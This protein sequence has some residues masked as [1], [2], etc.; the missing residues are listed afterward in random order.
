M[1]ADRLAFEPAAALELVSVAKGVAL[2]MVAYIISSQTGACLKNLASYRQKHVSAR[3]HPLQ[4]A[5]AHQTPTL[6]LCMKRCSSHLPLLAAAALTMNSWQ[7]PAV[8]VSARPIGRGCILVR[9]APTWLAHCFRV[10][11]KL[12]RA[13]KSCRDHANERVLEPKLDLCCIRPKLTM[14]SPCPT[15][16]CLPKGHT[17]C[18]H[19]FSTC[20]PRH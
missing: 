13:E 5:R 3:R 20:Q 17:T 12:V 15:E 16:Q 10:P 14:L 11:D 4:N 6:L 8:L 1:R 19:A 9:I 2:T 18:K 7:S